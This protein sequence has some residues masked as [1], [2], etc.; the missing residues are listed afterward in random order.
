MKLFIT[1]EKFAGIKGFENVE[2]FRKSAIKEGKVAFTKPKIGK[3][4]E[5]IKKHSR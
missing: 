4:Y 5:L 2:D 3:A 1:A